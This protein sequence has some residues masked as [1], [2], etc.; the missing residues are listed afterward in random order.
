MGHA[1]RNGNEGQDRGE[2]P[3]ADGGQ[4]CAHIKKKFFTQN[5]LRP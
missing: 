2:R 5:V 1:L 3:W 4:V